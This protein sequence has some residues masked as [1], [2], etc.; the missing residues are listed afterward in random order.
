VQT[1]YGYGTCVGTIG[2]HPARFHFGDNPGFVSFHAWL[3]DLAA[4]LTILGNDE[5]VNIGHIVAQ[6][7]PAALTDTGPQ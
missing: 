6:L 7:L 1:G 2:D 3:P 4:T 5:T